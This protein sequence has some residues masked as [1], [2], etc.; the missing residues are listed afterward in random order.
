MAT[1][2]HR[3]DG[4][5]ENVILY[6]PSPISGDIVPTV[7]ASGLAR[8][9]IQ[10][11]ASVMAIPG[12]A[13]A[14]GGIIMLGVSI[15]WSKFDSNVYPY[16]ISQPSSFRH[17]VETDSVGHRSDFFFP[18]LGSSTTSVSV[19]AT[20]GDA[21]VSPM[22][23]LRDKEGQNVHRSGTITVVGKKMR[24]FCADFQGLSGAWTEEQ[25]SFIAQGYVWRLTAS[26][27]RRYKALRSTMLRML[28]S[29]KIRP[30]ERSRTH[31]R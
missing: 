11:L 24:L 29:F 14:V 23:N 6:I 19:W 26:Y 25:V 8:C 2:R 22:Q 7:S 17:I 3:S 30:T 20:P 9:A 15:S 10:S 27:D 13:L 16:R 1:R 31:S 5:A 28:A 21:A 4:M 18:S 12:M